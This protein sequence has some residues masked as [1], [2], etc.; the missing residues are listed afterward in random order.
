M[1]TAILILLAA[2]L[3][4]CEYEVPLVT[5]PT[6]GIDEALVGVWGRELAN[7]GEERLLILPMSE[8]EYLVSFPMNSKDRMFARGSVWEDGELKLV[9]LEWF[10]T[11]KAKLPGKDPRFQYFGY[12]R[13]G[14]QLEILHLNADVVGRKPVSSEA[15]AKA[16]LA[17]KSD[18]KFFRKPMVFDKLVDPS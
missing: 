13:S 8:Q 18:P 14:E 1:R 11:A 10:G 17:K 9:Q 12:R 5:Q 15:L 2:L 16:I 7:G 6:A 3:A 4:G